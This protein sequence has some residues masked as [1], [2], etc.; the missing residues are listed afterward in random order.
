MSQNKIKNKNQ[1]ITKA[2][3]VQ[4]RDKL[5]AASTK[6][7]HSNPLSEAIIDSLVERNFLATLDEKP[8]P[9]KLFMILMTVENY[10]RLVSPRYFRRETDEEVTSIINNISSD[11]E[12]SIVSTVFAFFSN[13]E[14]PVT[15]L[16]FHCWHQQFKESQRDRENF[17]S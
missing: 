6:L 9:T 1:L 11:A 13:T 3:I 7:L 2:D 12:A 17:K 8:S 5:A 16:R 4:C 14:S 10:P 15:K